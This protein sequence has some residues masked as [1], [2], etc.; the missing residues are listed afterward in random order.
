[1]GT[2]RVTR[3]GCLSFR[4]R[5]VARYSAVDTQRTAQ[6]RKN[7]DFW[8]RGPKF[9]QRRVGPDDAGR[10]SHHRSSAVLLVVCI[11]SFV[12][13][14]SAKRQAKK[15]ATLGFRVG[16]INH[17]RAVPSDIDH[18]GI[19]S[20]TVDTIHDAVRCTELVF[21]R[22]VRERLHRASATIFRLNAPAA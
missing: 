10:S 8:I 14:I 3:D 21:S 5:S 9:C 22:D 16:A 13:A 15:A 20:R 18:G 7:F 11:A 6:H 1:M 12:L 4:G 19:T 2:R 17:L